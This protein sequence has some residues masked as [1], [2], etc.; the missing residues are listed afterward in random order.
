MKIGILFPGYGSQFIGMGKELYDESRTMQEYFEEASNCLNMNFVKLCFASSE[1]ELEAMNNA[2]PATFLVSCAMYAL[3]KEE[4]IKADVV[5]GY[6]LGEYA[7]LHAAGG[8]SFPDGLYLLAKYATLY[9][10]ALATMDVGVLHVQGLST[11]K[12]ESICKKSSEGEFSATIALYNSDTDH[13][14]SGH[15]PAVAAVRGFVAEDQDARSEELLLEVGLHSS[16]MDGVVDQLAPHL[17]KVDFKDMAIPLLCSTTICNVESGEQ[18]K[19]RVIDHIHTPVVWKKVMQEL[20]GC[21]LLVEVGPGSKLTRMAKE[22][23]PDKLCMSINKRSDIEDLK[24]I[25]AND[26]INTEI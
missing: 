26:G 16:L 25:I 1:S 10:E 14:V 6:N 11:K 3:L 15:G 18:V 17:A 8:I 24:K 9:Q 20:E 13:I 22:K 7:A 19:E 4:G 2:Y 5:A 23:Y 12:L 21:D